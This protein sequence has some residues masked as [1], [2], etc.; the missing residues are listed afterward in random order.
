MT[1]L[2]RQSIGVKLILCFGIVIAC[3]LF[4][5]VNVV[6]A[7]QRYMQGINTTNAAAHEVFG[8]AKDSADDFH[9]MGREFM[10]Y[11]YT[12]K[13]SYWEAKERIDARSD[14]QF[15]AIKDK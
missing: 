9:A 7:M 2:H 4:T 5:Y 14:A 3:G 6:R 15:D 11:V 8:L 1:L 10:G 12:G 13:Q